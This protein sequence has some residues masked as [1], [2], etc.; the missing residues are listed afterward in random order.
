MTARARAALALAAWLAAG[1]VDA[2]EVRPA[3]LELRAA[4]PDTV[5]VTWKVPARG[6]YRLAIAVRLP[7]DC[8]GEP[9]RQVRTGATWLERWQVRCP[10]GLAGREVVIAGLEAT[11]TDVLARYVRPDGSVQVARLTPAEPAFRPAGS[12]T[13]WAVAR[14]YV[15]LGVEHILLGADHLLF[16]LGL[17]LLVAGARPLV[18]TITAFTVAHSVT[19][20]AVSLGFVRVPS[21]PVEAVIAL[22]VMFVAAEVLR[23]RAG[24]PG[25][26]A[27]APWVVALAFGLLHGCGFAGAL[28]EIGLPAGEVPLALFC[29]NV[30][31]EAGQLLF[32]LLVVGLARALHRW[33]RGALRAEPVRGLVA[34]GIGA[35]AAFWVIDRVAGF[36][37]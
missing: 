32:V 28:A 12:P 11:R 36:W 30:G 14:T 3:Y 18:A 2:H 13:P 26:A 10:G 37:A 8:T 5:D 24:Q 27:R 25:F 4:G 15:A 17:L 31:V 33:S 20:A 16:V 6:D 21:A 9:P 22:S 35:V 23:A 7:A 34:Y 29:F 1:A 19:L